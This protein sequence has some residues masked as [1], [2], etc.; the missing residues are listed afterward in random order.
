VHCPGLE[1]FIIIV[2]TNVVNL[3]GR[4]VEPALLI[5]LLSVGAGTPQPNCLRPA[6][7]TVVTDTV[8]RRV[9]RLVV[10]SLDQ[11]HLLSGL[12]VIT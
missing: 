11:S 10:N 5:T 4:L 8:R 3:V 1:L 6:D 12:T 2:L 9:R 7:W